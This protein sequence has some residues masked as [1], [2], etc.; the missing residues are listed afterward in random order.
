MQD[1]NIV[2]YKD[3]ER[4]LHDMY[5]TGG[6]K[7]R[8][9]EKVQAV[10]GRLQFGS[11]ALT[12]LQ[13]TNHG[14]GRI[15]SCVK[16]DLGGGYRLITVQTDRLI[17][18]CFV[19]D[20]EDCDRWIGSNSGLTFSRGGNGAWEP[21]FKSPSIES[22]IRRDPSP[23]TEKLLDRME[24]SRVER[25]FEGVPARVVIELGSLGTIVT[26]VELEEK[27]A[28][29]EPEERRALVYDVLCLLSSGNRRAAERRFDLELGVAQDVDD[30]T[31]EEV[32]KIID[33]DE[34]RRLRVGSP[35]HEL[36]LERFAQSAEHME[37][38]LF[39]HP[40]QEA[41]VKADFNGPAKLSGVSGSGKTCV[42]IHR[43]LRL[44]AEGPG[45]PVL[46]VTLNR[47]LSGLIQR[48]VDA[49][50]PNEQVRRS[51][52]V[53]SFFQLCQE[54]LNEF[55]PQNQK[56]YADVTWKLE[57]HIDEVY[58]EYY[59]CWHN[60][61]EAAVLL[62]IH[63]SLISQGLCAET[64]IREEFDWI[65]SAVFESD[66]GRYLSLERMG[67][68]IPMQEEWRSRL[69]EGLLGWEAKMRDVGV[70]DYLGFTTAVS[71]HIDEIHA[72]F[73]HIV[74][75]E[76]QDFGTTELRLLRK[77]CKDGPND[78]FLC[79]DIAQHVLPKHRSMVEA[80]INVSGRSRRIVRNYRNSREILKAAYDVLIENLDEGM[81][82]DSDLEILDPV[83]ASRSSNEP[84]VL[85][86]E[87][88]EE[89]I[90]YARTLVR[91]HLENNPT[92]RCCIAFAGFSIRDVEAFARKLGL[93]ALH[94]EQGPL[95]DPVVLSDLEQTKGYEFNLVVILNC[96][97]G[98]LP[99]TGAPPDEAFRHG[100]RLYVAMTRARDE[101]Y[102]SYSDEPTKWLERTADSLSFMH[103]SEVV[104]IDPTLKLRMPERLSEVEHGNREDIMKL[105]GRD[106][107][108]TPEARGLSIEAIRKIDERVDGR[109]LRSG[110][111]RV[112]WK[113][114]A[115]LHRDLENEP[116]ARTAFGPVVQV[117]V[118]DRLSLVDSASRKSQK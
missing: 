92:H 31:D 94:G 8:R 47:S 63:Q 1:L 32:L 104:A 9:A 57:E 101:L 86:A 118:R 12:D 70:I 79:G 35:E 14:E 13:T 82:A 114:L 74:V 59:R 50:A 83:Y 41:V 107:L 108:Y 88:L 52:R 98:A 24:E 103:W 60:N 100:C 62:P 17:A 16:Y 56:L 46:I 66:R 65:R 77:L 3:F 75:D 97:M 6:E 117:E 48:L 96:A 95:D 105:N 20:H 115:I 78:L 87:S 45:R 68:R 34:V 11:D 44:A 61:G 37:W 39:L 58:R 43:A 53:C 4:S 110:G 72:R 90:G 21:I 40:E 69:V 106:F 111:H 81:L 71:R 10:L 51:I 26:T 42:A 28:R 38:L 116:R 84:V 64:Y 36:W 54:I 27:C 49:A 76:A 19:G 102:M 113:D 2:N 73:D 18:F 89:E 5:R 30:L 55:E 112:K 67:R 93:R 23:S 33:G 85:E 25:L 29:I 80:T 99:P 7:K 22:P 91:D 15:K 109:G